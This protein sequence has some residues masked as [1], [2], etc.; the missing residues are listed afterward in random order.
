MEIKEIRINK[1]FL[2]SINLNRD[3]YKNLSL[4]NYILTPLVLQTLEETFEVIKIPRANRAWNIIG[5]YGSGK[6]AFMLY[7]SNLLSKVNEYSHLEAEN[8]L[9]EKNPNIYEEY[10]EIKAK[11]PNGFLPILITGS[12]TSLEKA[13]QIGLKEALENL[14]LTDIL[15][16]YNP[17]LTKENISSDKIKEVILSIHEN[18]KRYGYDGILL[19]ID[20]FGKILEHVALNT[21][22]HD[23]FLLQD[24]AEYASRSEET[25]FLLFTILHQSF[26]QYIKFVGKSY[27]EE[28]EKI[29]GRFIEK[30]FKENIDQILYLIAN[31][32]NSDIKDPNLESLIKITE[33]FTPPVLQKD[34][35]INLVKKALPLHPS[36]FEILPHI[37]FKYAQNERSVFSFLSSLEPNSF[38]KFLEEIKGKN[39]LDFYYIFRLYDYLETTLS[40]SILQ[41]PQ[42]SEI[43]ILIEEALNRLENPTQIEID[44]IKTIGILNLIGNYGNIKASKEFLQ[45]SF[46]PKYSFSEIENALK[47]LERKKVI[48]YRNY[49][50][51]FVLWSGSDINIDDEL[52]LAKKYIQIEN[53]QDYVSKFYK[54]SPII[55]KRF[56]HQT[57]NLKIFLREFSENI[58]NT[59]IPDNIDGKIIYLL[60]KNVDEINEYKSKAAKIKKE[61]I[62]FIIPNNLP[63]LLEFIKELEA[64]YEILTK[65]NQ[66]KDKIAKK[67]LEFRIAEISNILYKEIENTFKFENCTLFHKGEVINVKTEKE[68]NE[69][70]S[71]IC[72]K[73]F[74]YIPYIKNELINRRKLSPSV[75]TAF[76]NLIKVIIENYN[77]ENLGISGYPPEYAIYYSLI[78][79]KGLH[80]KVNGHYEFTSPTD[81]S[82]KKTWEFIENFIKSSIDKRKSFEEG[83][84]TLQKPPYGLTHPVI[85]IYLLVGLVKYDSEIAIFEKGKF[86]PLLTPA[87]Y[88]RII[89]EPSN[90]EL[91]K[92]E[93]TDF[94]KEF[95]EK[96]AK[97]ILNTTK[98]TE[99]KGRKQQLLDVVKPIIL[100]IDSLPEYTKQ[101]KNLSE[102]S[103]NL[104]DAVL[105]AD[106]PYKLIFEDI[107]KALNVYLNKDNID[108]KTL[109]D[110]FKKLIESFKELKYHYQELLN[111]IEKVLYREF[112]IFHTEEEGKEELI[113]KLEFIE[114]L[115]PDNDELKVFINRIKDEN[116]PYKEWLES[117]AITVHKEKAPKD[118]NE[119]DIRSFDIGLIQIAKKVKELEPIAIELKKNK[120]QTEEGKVPIKI[121]LLIPGELEEEKVIILDKKLNKKNSINENLLK[122]INKLS[123]EE[124]LLL[125]ENL[126]QDLD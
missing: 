69:V 101:A 1:E 40:N 100:F 81:K 36:T 59:E 34:T 114:D 111:H 29:Y 6:S 98:I 118:W 77:V 35:F 113:Q 46:F 17:V 14:K 123:K 30:I 86:I 124:K 66:L 51:Q 44:I 84:E 24:L 91:Q 79:D 90:F 22:E 18:I 13:L 87:L 68:L 47:K 31:V 5:P 73:K 126:L 52:A 76:R 19:V 75:R 103:L 65:V 112:N 95:F 3:F 32:I 62:I 72:E 99:S 33:D 4:K 110:F 41:N 67:E 28:W 105:K 8:L 49:N 117:I 115:V 21:K 107:P 48:V 85:S 121:S 2:K 63:Q 10:L 70:I 16:I 7:L 109:E 55:A 104:R 92:Y 108:E 26:D 106:D 25:P 64:Y 82:L 23:I 50:N 12:R 93:I 20:E 38:L 78:K 125:I 11:Y 60:P 96:L 102:Y 61:D 56:Y 27:Q 42:G 37:F 74:K 53:I 45:Y 120:I 94:K 116:L 71:K 57:G 83:F 39:E 54:L 89:K 97:V 122:E 88:E 80:Q 15:K 43:W 58:K 9:K 119:E